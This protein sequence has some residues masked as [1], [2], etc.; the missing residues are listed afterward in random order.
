MNMSKTNECDL[1]EYETLAEV[2]E[3]INVS[4]MK[5]FPF[6]SF[7]F[8]LFKYSMNPLFSRFSFKHSFPNST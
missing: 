3:N 7:L 4:M 8:L 6:C 1:R 2:V 5:V